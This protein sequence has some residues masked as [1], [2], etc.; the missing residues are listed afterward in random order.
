MSVH[1]CTCSCSASSRSWWPCISPCRARASRMKS[2]MDDTRLLSQKYFRTTNLSAKPSATS[3]AAEEAV[4]APDGGRDGFGAGGQRDPDGCAAP[5]GVEVGAGSER[6][7]FA[8]E[9]R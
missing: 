4:D 9:Q 3:S 6:D 2:R 1:R 8:L 5:H 7:P